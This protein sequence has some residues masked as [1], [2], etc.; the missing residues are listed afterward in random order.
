M[1]KQRATGALFIWLAGGK[2]TRSLCG[3]FGAKL[4][5]TASGGL[6]TKR[7]SYACRRLCGARRDAAGD[8]QLELGYLAEKT[9]WRDGEIIRRRDHE[10]ALSAERLGMASWPRWPLNWPEMMIGRMEGAHWDGSLAA[11]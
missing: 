10:T 6:P 11:G 7:E 1:K 3:Q 9:R 5:E 4:R 8:P 2:L